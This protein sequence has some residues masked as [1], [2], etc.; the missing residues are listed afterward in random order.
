[1]PELGRKSLSAEE[2]LRMLERDRVILRRERLVRQAAGP[3][4]HRMV[5]IIPV[6]FR[7]EGRVVARVLRAEPSAVIAA[8]QPD[9][10]FA[11]DSAMR[12]AHGFGFLACQEVQAYLTGREPLERLAREGLIAAEPYPDTTLVRP[13]PGPRR[14]LA[15]LVDELPPARTVSGGFRI[16]T[17]ERLKRELVG[18]VGARTDLFALLEKAEGGIQENR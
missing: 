17:S 16:V 8:L 10:V 6:L 3:R 12:L 4:W 11:L 2:R 18:A 5:R 7:G 14:L 9:A 1:M 13:W 15:C